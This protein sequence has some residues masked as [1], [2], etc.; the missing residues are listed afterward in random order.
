MKES[1]LGSR[2]GGT[3]DGDKC[4]RQKE[5]CGKCRAKKGCGAT[6][7]PKKLNAEGSQSKRL[8]MARADPAEGAAAPQGV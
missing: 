1:S 8:E 5:R 4:S 3:K 6:E 2:K 7:F